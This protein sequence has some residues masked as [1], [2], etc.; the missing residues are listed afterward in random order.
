MRVRGVLFWVV[1][2]GLA[3]PALLL[4][5]LRLTTPDVGTAV[6]GVSFAPLALPLYAAALVLLLARIAWPAG[7]QRRVWVAA[8]VAALLPLG[9][10]G[11]WLAPQFSGGQ[12]AAAADARTFQV[13]TANLLTGHAD[14]LE[15]METIANEQVD[16]LVLQEVT[17]EAL[18][19][20]DEA[21]LSTALPER[22]GEPG[23][24]VMGTMILSVGEITEVSRLDTH[25][26]SY[27]ATVALPQGEV[28]MLGVHPVPPHNADVWS[29][30]LGVIEKTAD[31]RVDLLAGDFNATPDH[32]PMRGIYDAG[33]RDAAEVANAGWQPTWPANGSMV[34]LPSPPVVQIDH[35]L[36]GERLTALDTRTVDI[37]G[38]D[39]R[40]V[41]ADVA[42]V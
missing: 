6:R 35:V 4:T 34:G 40:A 18:A 42:F 23:F 31:D 29:G 30:E 19:A 13:M 2:A 1:L 17:P 33:F 32:A 10:H 3:L 11:W 9:L 26:G 41:I 22:A 20:L 36:V 21:G 38:T 8:T 27:A 16:I 7:R 24:G 14:P 15:V 37:T 12:P 25:M 5:V 28:R 39:H